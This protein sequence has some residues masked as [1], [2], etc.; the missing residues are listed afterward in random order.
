MQQIT[1]LITIVFLMMFV[2]PTTAL[3][4]APE[5]DSQYTIQV[6]DWLS[7]IAE[8]Y[9]GDVLAYDVIVT[10]AN[11]VDDD[12]YTNINNPDV[13]EPGW[14]LCIPEGETDKMTE[15]TT[16]G[17]D[18]MA[19]PGSAVFPAEILANLTYKSEFT[20]DGMAPLAD[21]EY[22]EQAA[23]GSAT[24]TKV[25]LTENIA[26]G[27]LEN[28]LAAVVV[29]VTNPGGSGTFYDL[30][31]VVDQN[32]TPTNISTIF[33]GDRVKI[34]AMKIEDKQIV[35]DMV[36]AGPDD[37]MCCPT[38]EVIR[39]FSLEA[40]T[41]T[42]TTPTDDNLDSSTQSTITGKVVAPEGSTLPEGAIIEV[43]VN[44]VSLADAPAK[45]IGGQ[46]QAITQFPI[47]FEA[48][49][50]AT[51][52]DERF[53]YALRVRISDKDGN[54]LYINTQA[55]NIITRDNP[56]TDV[57]VLVEPIATPSTETAPTT[58]PSSTLEL[59]DTIWLWDQTLMNNDET[60]VPDN[61]NN[62]SLQFN[63]DGT[64][65]IQADC[66]NAA[67]TYTVADGSLNIV[68]GPM[69]MA[70]C[71][72]DSLSEQFVAQLGGAAIYFMQDGKLFID[73]QFDS[74]TM[75][76]SPQSTQLV[77]PTWGVLGYNNGNQ[78]VVSL[79]NGTEITANFGEDGRVTGSA[80]CNDYFAT[81][82][83]EG[84]QIS[85]G[86][87]GLTRKACANPEGIMEQEQLL[88]EALQMADVYS[89]RGGQLDLRTSEGSRAIYFEVAE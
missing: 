26:Y 62:Y 72:E 25:L 68:L 34:N 33:L 74:G 32:G 19:Q 60:F 56:T 61:T 12:V 7:K 23:P 78:G 82:T 70:L 44:D 24:M 10:A 54:L 21:G 83:I 52:I 16:P 43:Q 14:T 18:A 31:V 4:Q 73:L 51:T 13:I 58:S 46:I 29:L 37:P 45:Q 75:Q 77:G 1:K 47:D 28:H 9:Y 27:E 30:A 89:I 8:Q 80:G 40:D 5:C 41:L 57:E 67:G 49:Y 71:P 42:E 2:I 38:Q 17:N 15:T 69:T 39:S 88:L 55:Y 59:V 6:D 35:I 50:D 65:S 11:A 36:Q 86:Q 76:F 20:Q 87:A 64:V 22:S 66:N 79:I 53:S 84:D 48:P 81:Y 3:A 63:V 85:I